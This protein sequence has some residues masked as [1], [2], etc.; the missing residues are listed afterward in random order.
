[1][2]EADA[3][4][5]GKVRLVKRPIESR[6]RFDGVSLH[7][8]GV[9]EGVVLVMLERDGERSIPRGDTILKAGDKL[10]AMGNIGGIERLIRRYMSDNSVG[11]DPRRAIIVGGGSV[12]FAIA[13]SLEDH[14]WKLKL[15]EADR[16]R[17]EE[18]AGQIKGLVL[19]GDGTDLSL[20]REENVGE[21][22]VLI[23]VT[24]NDEKNLLVS[25]L[26]KEEG[27]KRILTRAANHTNEQL[28]ESV[29]VDVVRSTNGAAVRAVLQGVLRNE[30]DFL[31]EFNHGDV[32]I[33]RLKVAADAEP[34][35]LGKMQ[36]PVFAIV[37]AI[38]RNEKVLIPRGKDVVQANDEL[39]VFCQTESVDQTREFFNNL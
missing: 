2:L 36:S 17:A 29:G 14:G 9:P 1:A 21:T 5:N 19:H 4:V 8:I 31:A 32:R 37:G 22:P 24:S 34:I 38:L 18:I 25:L 16:Q 30:Q 28:F 11:P 39:L 35:T 3:F 20:L 6:S 7:E 12:G 26:A 23:A 27:V 33:L 13:Q 10:T 15:I